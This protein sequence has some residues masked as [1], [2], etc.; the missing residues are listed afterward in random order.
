MLLRPF[1]FGELTNPCPRMVG[2]GVDLW[3]DCVLPRGGSLGGTGEGGVGGVRMGCCTPI[4]LELS[5][6][7]SLGGILGRD[8]GQS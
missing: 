6:G 4:R 1:S 8:V 7:G 2:L 3:D 5:R